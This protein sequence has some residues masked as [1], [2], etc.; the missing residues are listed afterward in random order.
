MMQ[1]IGLGLALT[2]SAKAVAYQRQAILTRSL[3]TNTTWRQLNQQTL[4]K[5]AQKFAAQ[6]GQKLTKK[7]L[8]QFVPIARVGIGAALNWKMVYDV[9][10]A[11]Y[12]AYRERFL[13]EKGGDLEPIVVD[14][15][16]DDSADEDGAES[17]IDV[18]DILESEVIVLDD[19]DD[20]D[21]GN[22]NG[23]DTK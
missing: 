21:E 8:G 12:W 4:V 15:E 20:F 3:A 18:I 6:F 11:A 2:P 9:S 7:K 1:V 5:V 13:Y 22:H 14:A 23:D 17:S 10:K 16:V 19:E